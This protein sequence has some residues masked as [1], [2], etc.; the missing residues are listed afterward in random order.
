MLFKNDT[1]YKMILLQKMM[2]FSRVYL[3]ALSLKS[4]LIIIMVKRIDVFCS[5][6]FFDI[7]NG[8]CKKAL[9]VHRNRIIASH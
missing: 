3:T 2:L 6:S 8:L 1:P 4:L 7:K 5:S 9:R